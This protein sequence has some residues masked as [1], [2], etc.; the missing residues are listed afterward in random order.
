MWLPWQYAVV[1]SVALGLWS[2]LARPT[3]RGWTIAQGFAREAALVFLLYS[4]WL[5]AGRVTFGQGEGALE[6]ARWVWDTQRV[7]GLPSELAMQ[8]AVLP[9]P[10]LVQAANV[11]YATVHAPALIVFLIWLFACHRDRYPLWRNTVA[12]VTGACLLIQLV[13]VAPPRF[14]T[15][16]GFV[17]TGTLYGQ[18]VYGPVGTGVSDQLSAMPSVHVAWAVIVA[19]AVVLVSTSRWRWL[20]LAHPVLTALVIVVTANHWWLDGVGAIVL[21]IA[22]VALLARAERAREARRFGPAAAAEPAEVPAGSQ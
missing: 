15:G 2:W 20:V 18:S 8:Q 5:I 7:L 9:H 4:I 3:R 14:L 1:C 22:T 21:I 19:A 17:D 16:L 13:P 12:I 11:F 10:V 6:R